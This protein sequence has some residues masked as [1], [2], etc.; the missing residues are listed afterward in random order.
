MIK[1]YLKVAWRNLI[2]NKGLSLINI[3]GLAIGMA[4]AILIG[5]WIQFELSFDKFH[6]NRDRIA[7]VEKNT[8]FNNQKNTQIAI[9]LPLY[10]ELKTNFPEVKR[11]SRMDWNNSHSIIAGDKKLNKHCSH[12][13]PD[14]LQM[15]S[16]EFIEGNSKTALNDINSCVLT[17]SL[18]ETL[19]PKGEAMGK[20]IRVDNKYDKKVTGILKD[21]PINSTIGFDY[22][23]PFE[24]KIQNE[25]FV[26]E[27]LTNW[28]NNF[29][30]TVVEIKEG[31][32]MEAFSKKLGPL[33]T[34][35]NTKLKNQTLFLHPMKK[36]HLDNEFKNWVN[37]GGKIEYVR[38]FGI[39]GIFVLLIACIN[40]M[41]LSTARSEKRAKE[42]GI[43]KA[44]GSHRTQ[45][46]GQFLSES[47]LTAF[48][49]F[50]L[51][52]A[53]VQLFLPF[54]K[55]IGFENIHFDFTNIGLLASVLGVCVLTG[56]LAGSYPALYLSSFAP[57]RVLKGLF[58]Q[59][60]AAARFR[61]VLVVSQ[62]AISIGLIISTIIVFM[63]IQKAKDRSLGYDP[64]N[65]ITVNATDDLAKNYL[66][67]KQELMNTGLIEA[68][69]KASSPMTAIYN[70][71]D[72]YSW[73]G[74]D[75]NADMIVNSVM[76]EYDYEKAIK[77]KFKAG[78]SFS[79]DF[80]TDSNAVI[81]NE[82]ALKMIGYKEPLGK[83]MKLGTQTLTI[84]GITENILMENPFEPVG[85]MAIIFVPDNFSSLFIRPKGKADTKKVI[86]AMTPLFEKYNPSLP[87][88]YHFVD[89]DF[90]RKF[91]NENH[92]GKLAGIFAGLAIFI[93]CLGLFGLAAFMAER[94][95]KEIGI[96]K[97]L[98]ASVTNLW[99]LLSR[100]FVLLVLL[101]C[102][103]AS[104]IALWVMKDWLE[105]Y[106][107]R[108]DISAWI[109]IST[110]ILAVFI[111]LITVS[112]QAVKAALA[113]PVKSLRTE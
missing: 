41:N 38:L 67:L 113:N 55:D 8:L 92:V 68:V 30:K 22:L 16:F 85:P 65:L 15:F 58:K 19:F 108:V 20:T 24:F 3:V 10:T 64:N 88:E 36:W 17:Q 56:L 28:G 99:L 62:F 84:I 79:R 45:L 78:R 93:S 77:L 87:F 9:P 72:D 100:E 103:I 101:A 107:F 59:G 13:D 76:T 23:A 57:V 6:A 60:K 74:K 83:T 49:A 33:P 25:S 46:I 14:F 73:E 50:L 86:A 53:L 106:D 4:F 111:A 104:P 69:S 66:V 51:S 52:L 110:G 102:I 75:P 91:T 90:S 61:K 98:G 39:I 27:N 1:N 97:V 63:Q 40:F 95:V 112:T 47:L 80:P 7:V 11:A 29:L 109:F 34:A 105:K 42:V 43:R 2:R 35:R 96:R 12:V 32:S 31:V 44:V 94:R 37:I 89:E 21:P 5:L 70:S 48:L 18:A 54:L 26:K 81:L 71:W 82:A